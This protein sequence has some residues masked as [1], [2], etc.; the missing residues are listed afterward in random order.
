MFPNLDGPNYA[1]KCAL[2]LYF[3]R[4]CYKNNCCR[5]YKIHLPPHH[6]PVTQRV[7]RL[8]TRISIVDIERKRRQPVWLYFI[9]VYVQFVKRESVLKIAE[10]I[11]SAVTD[12]FRRVRQE[13]M[14]PETVCISVYAQN[15]IRLICDSKRNLL[16]I[17]S[18]SV[19]I[20]VSWKR[21]REKVT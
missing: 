4:Y 3:L 6:H 1:R 7:E 20:V 16:L 14:L 21:S 13:K 2:K 5:S 11:S 19:Y 12:L 8:R 10:I 9:S 15:I 18:I 17:E